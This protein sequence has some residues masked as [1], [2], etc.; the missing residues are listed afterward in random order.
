MTTNF[1]DTL[2]N[3]G[4]SGP[5][6]KGKGCTNHLNMDSNSQLTY[7]FSEGPRWQSGNTLTSH[8]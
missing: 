6:L 8:L 3:V 7:M 2:L 4:K 1:K 5:L